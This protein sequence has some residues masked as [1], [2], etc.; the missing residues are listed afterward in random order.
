MKRPTIHSTPYHPV[1]AT[2]ITHVPE[3][4]CW[5]CC[6]PLR[7]IGRS[8]QQSE[9][10]PTREHGGPAHSTAS[11]ERAVS[12]AT[13]QYRNSPCWR[14]S[15]GNSRDLTSQLPEEAKVHCT[16][17]RTCANMAITLLEHTCTLQIHWFLWPVGL[18]NYRIR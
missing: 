2:S 3:P 12:R 9:D 5:P 13:P 11:Y 7:A 10:V 17:T 4:V 1:L 18:H 16:Y 6:A 8:C 14:S 15:E